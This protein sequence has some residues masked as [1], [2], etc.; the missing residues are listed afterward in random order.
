MRRKSDSQIL[1]DR[2]DRRL[3]EL[4]ENKE[5]F[6]QRFDLTQ[7]GQV[8]AFEI[9]AA[10]ETLRKEIKH[11][12]SQA[13]LATEIE[14]QIGHILNAR[15]RIESILGIGAQSTAYLAEDLLN[16][17]KV[18]LKIMRVSHLDTWDSYIAFQRESEILHQLDH[19]SL[20]SF[21]DAF[22]IKTLAGL[23]FVHAQS[24]IKA[25]DLGHQLSKGKLFKEQELK[26]IAW[27]ILN[28]LDYLHNA[29]SPILH[30]DLKPKNILRDEHGHIS[31]IDFG[32]VQYANLA[33]T[34]AMGTAGYMAPE[35]LMGNALPQSDLYGLGAT[36]V[37]L[38]TQRDPQELPLSRMRIVWR[39]HANLSQSFEDWIDHLLEPAVGDRFSSARSAIAALVDLNQSQRYDANKKND[40][41][42]ISN[43]SDSSLRIWLDGKKIS[44]LSQFVNQISFIEKQINEVLHIQSER[45]IWDRFSLN[46]HSKL[47]LPNKGL[48][49][50][51]GS[52]EEF[53]DA[54]EIQKIGQR[55][56]L[57]TTT[58]DP[59]RFEH[60]FSK[61]R[62][63][64]ARLETKEDV[65]RLVFYLREFIETH[66]L[67]ISID[68]KI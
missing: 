7:D 27:Q 18:A 58:F 11:E 15:F 46:T 66:D 63:K 5:A 48:S 31:L 16:S 47:A 44:F 9:N 38:A 61:Q 25:K 35:Q 14:I 60:S 8:D 20:P 49:E 30:R 39:G 3:D 51:F 23:T 54:F 12:I 2:I 26:S 32:A 37:R 43:P 50:D 64:V 68:V 24:Y 6:I 41:A 29:A 40:A 22:T 36:L 28:I 59:F 67:S 21:V 56:M 45:N 52:H 53:I 65:E 33:H 10:R 1:A 13:S 17:Q 19:T 34:I 62:I 4:L 42:E 57:F 55:Y